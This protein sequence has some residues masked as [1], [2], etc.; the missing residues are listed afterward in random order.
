VF[1]IIGEE[2]ATLVNEKLLSGVYSVSFTGENLPSGL[3]LYRL[4]T[5]NKVFTKKMM[6]LK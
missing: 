5:D 2:V 6:L 4:T 1:N 3:Y